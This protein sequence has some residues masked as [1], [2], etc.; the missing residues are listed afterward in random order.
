[1]FFFF[2]RL[3]LCLVNMKAGRLRVRTRALLMWLG[4]LMVCATASDPMSTRLPPFLFC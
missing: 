1:M 4:V 3:S 2:M